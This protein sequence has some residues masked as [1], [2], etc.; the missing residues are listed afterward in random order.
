M[1]MCGTHANVA[2]ANAA[3]GVVNLHV[4]S[5]SRLLVHTRV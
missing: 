1:S 4:E 5:V 3:D 2:E